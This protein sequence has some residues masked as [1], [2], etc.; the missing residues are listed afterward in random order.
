MNGAHLIAAGFA[1]AFVLFLFAAIAGVAF[2]TEEAFRW[3]L[4]IGLAVATLMFALT[5]YA[6]ADMLQSLKQIGEAF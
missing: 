2:K 1:V 6:V 3:T 4:S 5:A